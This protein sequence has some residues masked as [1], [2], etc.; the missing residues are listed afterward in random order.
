MRAYY[1]ILARLMVVPPE[2]KG[3]FDGAFAEVFQAM[4][5]AFLYDAGPLIEEYAFKTLARLIMDRNLVI[6][7]SQPD[8]SRV[9]LITAFSLLARSE[10]LADLAFSVAMRLIEIGMSGATVLVPIMLSVIENNETPNRQQISFLSSLA[11]FKSEKTVPVFVTETI[12]RR[13]ADN[14]GTFSSNASD[15][16]AS[17]K[18]PGDLTDR[19]YALAASLHR[20]AGVGADRW[21]AVVPLFTSILIENALDAAPNRRMVTAA[22]EAIYESVQQKSSEGLLAIELL[23]PYFGRLAKVCRQELVTLAED[24]ARQTIIAN[25]TAAPAWV[26][27]V[28]RTTVQVL[29]ANPEIAKQV[30]GIPKLVDTLTSWYLGK[31]AV[32][33]ECLDALHVLL[34]YLSVNLFR[35]PFPDGSSFPSS[36]LQA[37]GKG[38]HLFRVEDGVLMGVHED[39]GEKVE[40]DAQTSVGHFRWTA[41][42][43][44]ATFLQESALPPLDFP[45]ETT[46]SPSIAPVESRP[47]QRAFSQK[48]RQFYDEYQEA[49]LEAIT[50]GPAGL[51]NVVDEVRHMQSLATVETARVRPLVPR[52]MALAAFTAFG[53]TSQDNFPFSRVLT[54]N[55]F[56]IRFSELSERTIRLKTTASVLYLP[57]IGGA[58]RARIE[59]LHLEDTSPHYRE[60]LTGLGWIIDLRTHCGFGGGIDPLTCRSSVYYADHMHELMWHAAGFISEGAD[61]VIANH[62]H[63]IWCEGNFDFSWFETAV[64]DGRAF[65]V[66]HPLPTGL[67]SVRIVGARGLQA[68]AGF[69]NSVIMG[70]RALPAFVRQIVLGLRV[71]CADVATPFQV[72]PLDVSTELHAIIRAGVN[73]KNMV[74]SERQLAFLRGK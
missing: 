44:S 24:F 61:L 69:A 7:T 65:V 45:S 8:F 9:L 26:I 39:E 21:T 2:V 42:D 31:P 33:S 17:L 53:F 71:A 14:P 58:S 52:T 1:D 15:I 27:R 73:E 40:F 63:V 51:Q 55:D 43:I 66:I 74:A 11:L 36:V 18:S 57:D 49:E 59:K 34:A 5:G 19:V 4:L 56:R 72:P 62:T 30:T 60:F 3:E 37:P 50:D 12:A 13:L 46:A 41:T 23:I 6:R 64:A 22:I 70:K 38:T 10:E 29:V 67:F 54:N 20:K 47:P 25:L 32:P 68:E 16:L 35:Y 28:C 48:L